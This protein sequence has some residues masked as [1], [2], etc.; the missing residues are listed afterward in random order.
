MCEKRRY[1]EFKICWMV[2]VDGFF[3]IFVE[4]QQKMTQHT[5]QDA[6][7]EPRQVS[8]YKHL[9]GRLKRSMDETF[10]FPCTLHFLL[11]FGEWGNQY[12]L[13]LLRL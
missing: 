7:F 9:E 13:F 5:Q 4:P 2:M 6:T 8:Q 11:C 10:T 3:V 12:L 1:K